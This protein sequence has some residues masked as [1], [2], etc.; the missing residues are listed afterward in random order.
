MLDRK[1]SLIKSMEAIFMI[2]KKFYKN[3]ELNLMDILI[4]ENQTEYEK[5]EG[6][7]W[8]EIKEAI[9]NNE[10]RKEVLNKIIQLLPPTMYN[11]YYLF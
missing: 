1:Q 6:K 4:K 5:Q 8:I 9:L 11:K 3:C 2:N 7:E 10:S